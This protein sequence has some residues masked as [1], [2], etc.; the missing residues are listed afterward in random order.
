MMETKPKQT[1]VHGAIVS[2]LTQTVMEPMRAF[3]GE[4]VIFLPRELGQVEVGHIPI[5]QHE[6]VCEAVRGCTTPD[7]W[8]P[9]TKHVIADALQK[10]GFAP[11]AL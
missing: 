10:A 9:R 5:E 1:N 6:E 4:T 7:C 11:L 2:T 3:A 8:G